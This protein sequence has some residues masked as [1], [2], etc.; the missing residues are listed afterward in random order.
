[1]VEQAEADHWAS[2]VQRVGLVTAKKILVRHGIEYMDTVLEGKRMVHRY[3]SMRKSV[4]D[5]LEFIGDC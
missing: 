2:L 3:D 5:I 4:D 1:M